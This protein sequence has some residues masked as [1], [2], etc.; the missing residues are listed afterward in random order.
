MT[1]LLDRAV[2]RRP[3]RDRWPVRHGAPATLAGVIRD[4]QWE[5]MEV[6]LRTPDD[7]GPD[8]LAPEEV[9]ALLLARR[10]FG[11]A[12]APPYVSRPSD[13]DRLPLRPGG[14]VDAAALA[15]VQRRAW[16][17]RYRGLLPDPF[18]DDLDFSYLGPAWAER[19]T[20]TSYRGR[21]RLIVAGRPG[22]VHAV[23]ETCPA[24]PTP[25]SAGD[26]DQDGPGQVRSLYVDPSV[27]G[28][29][30]GSVLLRAAVDALVADGFAEAVLWVVEGNARA[31]AFY[32]R[33]G[34]RP[35]GG[36]MITPIDDHSFP[37]IR[38]HRVL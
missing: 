8:D 3:R 27:A 11:V 37:A 19:A 17:A 18:L 29:G 21:R 35:D 36:R 26:A 4:P 25:D 38:Y 32:E 31:R 34:W 22:E 20:A 9:A 5:V 16:R 1:S 13:P 15:V 14:P 12:L 30:L 24:G 23:V 10:R 33:W 28:R 6:A 2:H 7:A